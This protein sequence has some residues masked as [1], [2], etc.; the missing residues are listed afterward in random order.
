M[1]NLI[2]FI[3]YFTHKI[4]LHDVYM[5]YCT[6]LKSFKIKKLIIIVWSVKFC[7]YYCFWYTSSESFI[8]IRTEWFACQ[9]ISDDSKYMHKINLICSE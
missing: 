1:N 9:K 8:D 3:I 6:F 7:D 5:I 4:Y 2:I